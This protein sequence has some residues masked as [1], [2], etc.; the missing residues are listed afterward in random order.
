VAPVFEAIGF[1]DIPE[2][3]L[4]QVAGPNSGRLMVAYR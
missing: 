1:D 3:L 2:A 4:R